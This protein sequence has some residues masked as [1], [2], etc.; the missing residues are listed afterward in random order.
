MKVFGDDSLP[1]LFAPFKDKTRGWT[2]DN[3]SEQLTLYLNLLGYGIGGDKSLVKTKSKTA[4]KPSWFPDSVDF[5]SYTHPSHAKLQENEDIIESLFKHF[6][7][8]PLKDAQEGE[9]APKKAKRKSS[10]L[11]AS[12]LSDPVIIGGG[13]EK[14]ADP[15]NVDFETFVSNIPSTSYEQKDLKRK[16]FEA[17][18]ELPKMKK[19]PKKTVGKPSEKSDYEKMRDQNVKERM[20]EAARLGL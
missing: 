11:G 13:K 14:P 19:V 12:I 8:D 5:D 18:E 9:K 15:D 7:L 20:D 6:G 4:S 2:K 16:S 17:G 1:H 10:L 3:V